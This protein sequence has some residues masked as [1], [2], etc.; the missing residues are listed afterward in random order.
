MDS[1]GVQ[2]AVVNPL[3]SSHYLPFII[4]RSSEVTQLLTQGSP[5]RLWALIKQIYPQTLIEEANAREVG[6]Q[7]RSA[8]GK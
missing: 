1:V 5:C 7:G 3:P 8:R 4:I 6:G 2:P